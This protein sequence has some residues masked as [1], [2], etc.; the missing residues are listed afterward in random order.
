MAMYLDDKQQRWLSRALCASGA[1]GMVGGLAL[2]ISNPQLR[3]TASLEDAWLSGRMQA[4]LKQSPA[5]DKRAQ[6]LGM[7]L[8]AFGMFLGG[9]GVV[10][11]PG[12]PEK[13]RPDEVPDEDLRF[14]AKGGDSIAPKGS[15]PQKEIP[16]E[17]VV[18]SSLRQKLLA[19]LGNNEW[20]RQCLASPVVVLV[21]DSGCGKSTIANAICVLRALLWGWDTSIFDPHAEENMEYGLWMIGTLYGRDGSDPESSILK[22]LLPALRKYQPFTENKGKRHTILFDEFTGWADGSYPFLKPHAE[23]IMSHALRNVRKFGHAAIFNLHGDKKGTAGGEA[24]GSGILERLLKVAAVIRVDGKPDEWGQVGWSGTGEFKPPA[25][26]YEHSNF[27]KIV[28][29]ELMSPG[30]MQ[31]EIGDILEYLRMDLEDPASDDSISDA[32][33]VQ[34][35]EEQL[36]ISLSPDAWKTTLEKAY[37]AKPSEAAHPAELDPDWSVIKASEPVRSMLVYCRDRD[38]RIVDV[39]RLKGS[40]GKCQGVTSKEAIREFVELLISARVAEWTQK[41]QNGEGSEFRI[42]PRWE[43]YPSWLV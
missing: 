33:I 32:P 19:L 39:G 23:P 22:G 38:M 20:L 26:D 40:W 11:A 25:K 5:T 28:V 1:F 24:L 8:F 17:D 21:G 16:A 9:T 14:L 10:V 36:Q 2:A 7:L 42:V 4:Q 43:N 27:Q 35:I 29:P 30:R 18:L 34:K 37:L 3:D 15:A 12:D 31:R 13:L 41:N 6:G